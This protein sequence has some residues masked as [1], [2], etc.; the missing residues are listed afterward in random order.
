MDYG[1][2]MVRWDK[3]HLSFETWCVFYLWFDRSDICHN[4]GPIFYLWLNKVSAKHDDIIKWKHFPRYWPFVRVIHRSPVNSPHKGQWCGSLMFSLICFWINGWVNN[5]EAGDLR[6]YHAHYD[7][8]VMF[9]TYID[10]FAQDCSNS[11]AIGMELLQSCTKLLI[12]H[13]LTHLPL[14][15]HVCVS[16]S[17]QHWFR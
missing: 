15:P 3:K 14:M 13:W 7:V 10:G 17:G 11:S 4:S 9:K 16:E 5:R 6:R 2:T 12:C 8:T 1:K